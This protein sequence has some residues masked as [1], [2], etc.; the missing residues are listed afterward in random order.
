VSSE[1]IAAR[2][3]HHRSSITR[4]FVKSIGLPDN[5]IPELKKGFGRPRK[6]TEDLLAILKRQI[7]KYPMMTAADL[8]ESTPELAGVAHRT[9]AHALQNYLKVPSRSAAMKP[10]LT[11]KMKLKRLAFAK[12]HKYLTKED[13]SK[14][15]FSDESTFRCV[16]SIKTQVRRPE[17]SSRFDI[18]YTLK[19]VKHVL[20]SL[21]GDVFLKLSDVEAFTS[22]PRT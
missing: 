21:C 17:G 15:M 10:L 13:W 7:N 22:F 12:K 20:L 3:G 19:T 5:A 4:L 6:M 14:E 11:K 2:L 8:K 16:R 9:I 18:Q 1:K